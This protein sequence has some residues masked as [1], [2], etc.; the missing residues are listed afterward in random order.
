[1]ASLFAPCLQGVPND[2]PMVRPF[3]IEAASA[4]V[5]YDLVF[6]DTA[7]N[8]VK[9][10]GADPTLIL[11]LALS[12]GAAAVK[13]IYPGSAIPVAI[14]SPDTQLIMASATTPGQAHLLRLYGIEKTGNNWRVDTTDTGATRVTVLDYSPHSGDQGQEWFVVRFLAAQLQGDSI[15][16]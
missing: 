1:M 5:P 8:L 6:L 16:S 2:Y 4:I 9:P 11:G 15:V 10:C 3:Q 7:D 14:L 13:T 12:S